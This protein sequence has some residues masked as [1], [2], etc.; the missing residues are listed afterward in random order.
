MTD[1]ACYIVCA[2]SVIAITVGIHPA[3]GAGK[4]LAHMYPESR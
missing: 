4:S 3:R 1:L 2:L